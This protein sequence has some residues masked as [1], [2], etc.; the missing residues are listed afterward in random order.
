[1]ARL[2][3]D[4]FGKLFEDGLHVADGPQ[5]DDSAFGEGKGTMPSPFS[6]A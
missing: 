5:F 4:V 6:L 1:M 2:I 3:A